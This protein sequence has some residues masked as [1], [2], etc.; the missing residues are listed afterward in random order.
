MHIQVPSTIWRPQLKTAIT[1]KWS[2]SYWSLWASLCLVSMKKHTFF[3]CCW[4]ELG[5]TYL[6]VYMAAHSRYQI[7]D[8]EI[9]LDVVARALVYTNTVDGWLHWPLKGLTW[10]WQIIFHIQDYMTLALFETTSIYIGAGGWAA[11]TCL[12]VHVP[13]KLCLLGGACWEVFRKCIFHN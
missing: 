11:G 6:Y 3:F 1:R 12:Q 5:N 7:S 8:I 2:A 13:Y 10:Q 9:F 4:S